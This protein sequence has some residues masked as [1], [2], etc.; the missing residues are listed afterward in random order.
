M[1]APIDHVLSRLEKVR[2][3]GSG[4]YL[5]RCPAHEDRSPSLSISEGDNGCVLIRCFAGCKTQDVVAALGLEMKDLFHKD[6]LNQAEKRRY[7]QRK[8]IVE[9]ENA[10]WHELLVLLQFVGARVSDRQNGCDSRYRLQRPE[11]QPMNDEP[12]DRELL[13]ARRIWRGLE[14]R[15]GR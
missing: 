3:L 9:I 6:E 7:H 4:R 14:L 11:F 8:T 12:W 2:S 13:A 10:L 5:S 15:Y 1:T